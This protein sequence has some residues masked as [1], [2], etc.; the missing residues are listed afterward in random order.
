MNIAYS[1]EPLV[2]PLS[3]WEHIRGDELIDVDAHY[4]GFILWTS[5]GGIIG[6]DI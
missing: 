6:E 2:L 1:D 3:N 5:V 4:N